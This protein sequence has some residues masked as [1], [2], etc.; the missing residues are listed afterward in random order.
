MEAAA[1]ANI[2]HRLEVAHW[3]VAKGVMDYANP[4]KDDRYKRFAARASAEVLFKLLA[5]QVSAI[6][7]T[8]PPPRRRSASPPDGPP[9]DGERT[10]RVVPAF[11][12]ALMRLG[13]GPWRVFLS[14]TQELAEFPRDNPFVTAAKAAVE[15]AGHASWTASPRPPLDVCQDAVR[16][17]QVFAAVVG[18]RYGTPVRDYPSRSYAEAEFDAAVQT[19]ITRLI[20]LV[21]ED[22]EIVVPRD[23]WIDNEYADRQLAFRQRIAESS[24]FVRVRDP[25]HLESLL[26]QA[27]VDLSTE[28]ARLWQPTSRPRGPSGT[29]TNFSASSPTTAMMPPV[30]PLFSVPGKVEGVVER[31]GILERLVTSVMTPSRQSGGT[32]I[33]VVGAGGFGKTVLARTLVNREDVQAHFAQG[34]AWVNVGKGVEGPELAGVV[35]DLVERLTGFRPAASDPFTAGYELGQALQGRHILLVVNDVWTA[36]QVEPF[37]QGGSGVVRLITTRHP[38][39]LPE[40]TESRITVAALTES[41]SVSLLTRRL[42]AP[43]TAMVEELDRATGRWP[44]LQ[45]LVNGQV[46]KRVHRG[47]TEASALAWVEQRLKEAGPAALDISDPADRTKAVNATLQASLDLLDSQEVDRYIE[48][49]IFPQNVQVP[50]PVLTRYWHAAV[51]WDRE[52]VA[53]FCDLLADYS[54]LADYRL[55]PPVHRIQIHDVIRDWLIHKAGDRLSGWHARLLDAHRELAR[56][57]REEVKWW[58]LPNRQEYLW[59]WVPTHLHEAGLIDELRVLLQEPLWALGKLRATGVA[60]LENDLVM[61]RRPSTVALARFVRQNAHLLGDLEPAGSLEVTLASRLPVTP[62]LVGFRRRL[63]SELPETRLW[64]TPTL[65]DQPHPALVRVLSGHQSP[66]TGLVSPADADWL[67]SADQGG[68]VR[69]WN[70]IAGTMRNALNGRESPISAITAAPDGSWLVASSEDGAARLWVLPTEQ[71][72]AQPLRGHTQPLTAFCQPAH[73]PWLAGAGWDGAVLIWD[74]RTGEMRHRLFGHAGMVKAVACAP[75]GTWLVSGGLDR[76]V[77]LWHLGE[78]VHQ[79]VLAEGP[80]PVTTV[81]VDPLGRWLA[82]P[83]SENAVGVWDSNGARMRTLIGRSSGV[84]ALV[85]APDGDLLAVAYQDGTTCLWDP[86]KGTLLHSLASA[87][88]GEPARPVGAMAVAGDGTWLATASGDDTQIWETHSGR[89]RHTL[90]GHTDRVT[91]LATINHG[92]WLATAGLD[93]MVRIWDPAVTTARRMIAAR[94]RPVTAMAMAMDGTWTA[95]GYEDGSIRLWGSVTGSLRQMFVGQSRRI[96]ALAAAPNGSWLASAADEGEVRIWGLT[97]SA[98]TDRRLPLGRS[99]RNSLLAITPD[100]NWLITAGDD[101]RVREWDPVTGRLRLWFPPL[102]HPVTALAVARD[103]TWLAVGDQNGTVH[104]CDLVTGKVADPL[105]GHARLICAIAISHDGQW[106]VTGGSDSVARLWSTSEPDNDADRLN[107]YAEPLEGHIGRLTAV[108]IAPD[109]QHLASAGE[110]GTVRLWKRDSGEVLRILRGHEGAINGLAFGP[111]GRWL[112]TAGEDRTVRVWH[113]RLGRALAAI[114]VDARQSWVAAC[115]DVVA[116][117]GERGPYSFSFSLAATQI[118][119]KT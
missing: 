5:G 11:T 20:F 111:E 117:A 103:G 50:L 2:A 82:A 24:A 13:P 99:A 55:D 43:P 76:T 30:A 25:R 14:H 108:A 70:S 40:G 47:E 31:P 95:T 114:R 33:G 85:A 38:G 3:V 16:R 75:D 17:S 51:G 48:L 15:R 71:T 37:V 105:Q 4:R 66:V 88:A 18:F 73:R 65:P 77:R 74:S 29:T 110:D 53:A 93:G 104:V 79:H 115:K 98:F 59:S 61:D 57:D 8:D 7:R 69:L 113:T 86:R 46:R 106:M 9:P 78:E 89:R 92:M 21:D 54:L 81:A 67:A 84:Q 23:F 90:I 107:V 63:M 97:R 28:Q 87:E 96:S 64:P 42:A 6:V 119:G 109:G 39:V 22:A 118:D 56:D 35:N 62:Q 58:Q 94:A 49:A 26:F 36:T 83:I 27:L 19:G 91:D 80:E 10:S 12:D 1:I 72:Q 44:L 116:A 112:V 34:I 41:E 68:G 32:T 102:R 100:S 45:A 101:G 60:G 52:R